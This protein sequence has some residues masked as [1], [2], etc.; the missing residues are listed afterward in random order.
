[1]TKSKAESLQRQRKLARAFK[2]ERQHICVKGDMF[3]FAL[4]YSITALFKLE[5]ELSQGDMRA[6]KATAAQ[7]SAQYWEW[8]AA[9][10]LVAPEK[11]KDK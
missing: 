3:V 4:G 5:R 8:S 10:G 2:N 11:G 1:M 7:L 9:L 6:A